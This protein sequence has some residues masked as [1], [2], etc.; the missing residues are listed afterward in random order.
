M[1][2]IFFLTALFAG[3]AQASSSPLEEARR[4]Y[5][6]G[7]FEEAARQALISV[8]K[9]SPAAMDLLGDL[10]REGKGVRR[11]AQTAYGWYLKAAS[12]DYIPSLYR[13]GV[14]AHQGFGTPPDPKEGLRAVL[15]AGS[16]P[17]ANLQ[18]DD[19]TLAWLS[20]QASQLNDPHA[21]FIL[22][23]ALQN[24]WGVVTDA[25][26]AAQLY[27]AAAEHGHPLAKI[28]LGAMRL[29]GEGVPEDARSALSLFN[30]AA[31]E[32]HAIALYNYGLVLIR[33]R[34][35]FHDRAGGEKSLR[36]AAAQ[37]YEPAVKELAR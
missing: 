34:G 17:D 32:G 20:Y 24:G 16:L 19:E 4:G 13:I 12:G 10:F 21:L 2:L 1:P 23:K 36:R 33:E 35:P 18:F 5:I 27:A 7:E 30:D 6:N 25:A 3:F 11:D 14:Y 22:G 37:G 28:N 9:H 8:S 26:G 29:R 15:K 31:E